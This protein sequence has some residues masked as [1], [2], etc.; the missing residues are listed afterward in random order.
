MRG[1][2]GGLPSR[3]LGRLVGRDHNA[4]GRRLGVDDPESGECAAVGEE[5]RAHDSSSTSG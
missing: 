4:G 2:V 3:R 1:C 5:A